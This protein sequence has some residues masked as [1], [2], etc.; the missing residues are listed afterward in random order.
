MGRKMNIRVIC[1]LIGLLA[2]CYKTEAQPDSLWSV[3]TRGSEISQVLETEDNVYLAL[4][5]RNG[6][7]SLGGWLSAISPEGE[8]IWST[9]YYCGV[10][11]GLYGMVPTADN[12][13]ALAGF[14]EN[15]LPDGGD[16]MLLLVNPEGEEVSRNRYGGASS[17]QCMGIANAPEGGFMLVGS[18]WS[19]GAGSSDGWIVRTNSEG[20]SLWSKTYGASSYERFTSIISTRD[21]GFA[22]A[23]YTTGNEMGNYGFWL[24]RLNADGDSLWSHVYGGGPN[25]FC[26][27]V[28]EMDNGDFMLGGFTRRYRA[29]GD[30][31]ML[32]RVSSN[33]DFIR[34]RTFGGDQDDQ[35]YSMTKTF[36]N[37]LVMAGMT[38][39]FGVRNASIWMV[40]VNDE[41]DI[42]WSRTFQDTSDARC[43]SI[44]QA[45]DSSFVLG[46]T[47]RSYDFQAGIGWLV[48]TGHDPLSV[49]R[50][51]LPDFPSSFILSPPYPNPF[52]STTRIGF[53]LSARSASSALNI[54]I[55]DP[56][57][58][59][60]ADLIPPGTAGLPAGSHS[61]I[62]NAAGV[63]AG[64]YL[65]RL[66]AGGLSEVAGVQVVK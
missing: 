33:G 39:S 56:L 44:I 31:F 35:C 47:C 54:A 20:D 34:R 46:G 58:R 5:E 57:G 41:N 48:K 49:P 55:F 52:N 15:Y 28:V 45:R 22:I 10:F 3:R 23:G 65:I 13:M 19:F 2:V 51:P 27:T 30:A 11:G 32:I 50:S 6:R 61:V 38:R 60:I 7:D 18:T 21:G 4:V 25:D 42:V 1:G 26:H 14:F 17:D 62:W 64:H 12:Q 9:R 36:D 24:V 66:E 8:L 16:F 37:Q 53:N 43:R 29:G 59:R 40:K 63:P